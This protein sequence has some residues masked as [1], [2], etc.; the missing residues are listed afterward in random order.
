MILGLGLSEHLVSKYLL[1]TQSNLKS[2]NNE[3]IAVVKNF[4][5]HGSFDLI[6]NNFNGMDEIDKAKAIRN[7]LSTSEDG[8][9]N[10]K[11]E[12]PN[13]MWLNIGMNPWDREYVE[14]FWFLQREKMWRI[15]FF[16]SMIRIIHLEKTIKYL[17][18][19]PQII[20]NQRMRIEKGDGDTS[21]LA[22]RALN[23]IYRKKAFYLE[24]LANKKAFFK[25]LIVEYETYDEAVPPSF[26]MEDNEMFN[27]E[28]IFK[29]E[30]VHRFNAIKE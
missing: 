5:D 2:I 23:F 22:N 3:T 10:L 4:S 1:T 25:D 6:Q 11:G 7:Y 17:E 16:D 12:L 28:N 8:W 14:N 21:Y 24:K 19:N 20:I 15:Q 13:K 18:K 9:R 27:I 30:N 29:N 26:A